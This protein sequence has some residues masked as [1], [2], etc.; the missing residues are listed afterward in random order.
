MGQGGS[1]SFGPARCPLPSLRFPNGHARA[2]SATGTTSCPPRRPK[3]TQEGRPAITPRARSLPHG[4]GFPKVRAP[5]EKVAGTRAFASTPAHRNFRGRY[6]GR[7]WGG[8]GGGGAWDAGRCQT[9]ASAPPLPRP[10]VAAPPAPPAP[11]SR[12]AA[13]LSSRSAGRE[14]CGRGEQSGG[15]ADGPGPGRAERATPPGLCLGRGRSG[16]GRGAPGAQ[17]AASGGANRGALRRLAAWSPARGPRALACVKRGDPARCPLPAPRPH[18]GGSGGQR[19]ALGGGG[20]RG[21]DARRRSGGPGAARAKPRPGP[22]PRARG[23]DAP[24]PL[25]F[26]SSAALSRSGPRAPWSSGGSAAAGS[27]TA[28]SCRP[29]TGWCGPRPL[30]STWRRR[31]ATGSSCA[32]CCTTSPPAPSTS[33]TSTSGRRC[34]R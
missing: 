28:R 25:H 30:S 20:G 17:N 19:G 34:P 18:V 7:K 5:S 6:R 26:G 1:G 2:P 13:E 16:G 12:R 10:A 15:D 31:C 22:E 24:R 9:S 27:S 11:R 3:D 21:G 4:E 29:T 33:R 8:G 32:S 14:D 23:R